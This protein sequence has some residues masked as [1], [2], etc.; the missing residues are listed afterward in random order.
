MTTTTIPTAVYLECLKCGNWKLLDDGLMNSLLQYDKLVCEPLRELIERMAEGGPRMSVEIMGQAKK[1]R[2]ERDAALARVTE[3]TI[4]LDQSPHHPI[5]G[6]GDSK[7]RQLITSARTTMDISKEIINEHS[8]WND[9]IK[10]LK[11]I[12]MLSDMVGRLVMH[13]V[14]Q[15]HSQENEK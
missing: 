3:M 7:T 10:L 8:A 12:D 4:I 15:L 9:S 1:Y 2:D 13:L 11:T 6:H 14:D 5:Q